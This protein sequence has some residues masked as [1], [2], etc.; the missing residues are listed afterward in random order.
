MS[1]PTGVDAS[2]QLVCL[3]FDG[4]LVDT[5][6]LW[7]AAYR[8]V[9]RT[10]AQELPPDWWPMIA[11]KSMAASA[12]VFGVTDPHGQTEIA[13]LLVYTATQLAAAYPPI[14]LPGAHDLFARAEAANIAVR[15]VTSTFTDLATLLAVAANFPPVPITGGDQVQAGKPAPDIYLKACRDSDCQPAYAVA[16]EDSTSGVAAATAAG[17]F[18]YDIGGD[19]GV[20]S[21]RYRN[22]RHLD[23]VRFS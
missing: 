15:I 5:Q 19:A 4:T 22:I 11:G 6:P 9:A 1:V 16:V 18:V 13:E 7:M 12:S 20:S 21:P 8:Q 10:R 2:C 3:D 14:V 17:L 23:E